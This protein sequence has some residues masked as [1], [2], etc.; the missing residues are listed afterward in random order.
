MGI[1]NIE[2]L[3]DPE[4]DRRIQVQEA[5]VAKLMKD[6]LRGKHPYGSMRRDCPLCQ[7]D[8]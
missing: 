8:K 2:V 3:M 6:H 5:L 7:S 4:D 1:T